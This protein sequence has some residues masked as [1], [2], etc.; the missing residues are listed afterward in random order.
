MPSPKVFEAIRLQAFEK[1]RVS[2]TVLHD[3]I[4][5]KLA[6]IKLNSER[7]LLQPPNGHKKVLKKV[8]AAAWL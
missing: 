8:V 2:A 4:Q 7:G 5:S 1:V 6:F 3:L